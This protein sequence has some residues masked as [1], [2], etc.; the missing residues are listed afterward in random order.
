MRK[1][2]LLTLPRFQYNSAL[3]TLWQPTGCSLSVA[4]EQTHLR[5]ATVT[6]VVAFRTGR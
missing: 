1:H 2:T 6:G 3:A 5:E 4:T